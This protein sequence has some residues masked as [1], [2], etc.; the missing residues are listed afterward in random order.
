MGAPEDLLA[1][2]GYYARVVGGQLDL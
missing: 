2:P 1:E